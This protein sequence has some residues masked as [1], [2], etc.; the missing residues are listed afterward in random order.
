MEKHRLRK[1]GAKFPDDVNKAIDDLL[2][3]DS[4]GENLKKVL[5]PEKYKKVVDSLSNFKD[6]GKL[7]K[8]LLGNLGIDL[9]SLGNLG[10]LS[11]ITGNIP[12]PNISGNIP[13][14]GG[15]LGEFNL[16]GL[17]LGRIWW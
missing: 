11:G 12:L 15:S 4:K 10:G 9:G 16:G 1:S 14:L 5:D 13:G 3:S 7:D 17:N 2:K 8:N 6:W